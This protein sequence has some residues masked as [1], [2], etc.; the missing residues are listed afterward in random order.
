MTDEILKEIDWR[1]KL[2]ERKLSFRDNDAEMD[3]LAMVAF[4]Y[5]KAL[6]VAVNFIKNV[7]DEK[8]L[9]SGCEPTGF[10]EYDQPTCPGHS[11]HETVFSEIAA[12]LGV[13]VEK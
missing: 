13:E 5:G 12:I 3:D 2:L 4:K 6:R 7:P 10:G 8:S 1:E 11:Y 9:C